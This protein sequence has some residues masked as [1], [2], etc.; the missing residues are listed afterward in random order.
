VYFERGRYGGWPANGGIWSWGNEILFGFSRGY[1]ND[2][3]GHTIDPDR[4]RQEIFA[5]SLDG[6]ES[7]AIE[8]ENEIRTP[9]AQDSPD[10]EGAAAGSLN[11]AMDFSHPDFALT[12]RRVDNHTGPSYF[13]HSENRGRSWRGPFRLPDI[14][15]PG[16]AARTDYLV[17]G[18]RSLTAFLTAAKSDGFE[19]RPFCAR[20]TDGG[21]TW[22]MVSWIGP[23]PR[24]YSI[25]PA[26]VRLGPRSILVAVRRKEEGDGSRVGWIESYLSADNGKSWEH[27]GEPARDIGSNPPSLIELEDK[28]LCLTY[29]VRVQPYRICARLS[30]DRGRTWSEEIVLRDD[31]ANGDLGYCRTVQRPD[32]DVVTVYYFNDAATGPERYIGATIWKPPE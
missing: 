29:G 30:S 18:R 7:W 27:V 10:P 19:G 32:G 11:K 31:G 3:T 1:H 25:M 28:R 17:D 20:T 21:L 6:G 26:S 13:F 9:S 15:T 8:E 14:G 22:R 2:K 4:P 16:I 5:R 23:E 12:L 24:G